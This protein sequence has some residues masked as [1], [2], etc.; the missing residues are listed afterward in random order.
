MN[1]PYTVIS[2]DTLM[3]RWAMSEMDIFQ[4]VLNRHLLPA[5]LAHPHPE[6]D[7]IEYDFLDAIELFKRKKE[8]GNCS[9]IFRMSDIENLERK[10]GGKLSKS[11]SIISGEKL[12][13][14]W[15][16]SKIE[17]EDLIKNLKLDVVDPLNIKVKDF[18][19]MNYED[20]HLTPWMDTDS[21]TRYFRK[22]DVEGL[23]KAHSI[24]PNGSQI[25]DDDKIGN[26]K[27]LNGNTMINYNK[28]LDVLHEKHKIENNPQKRL[29]LE[30]Y[31]K[32]AEEFLK[33]AN[34]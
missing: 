17:I 20:L 12:C 19:E 23:E 28:C 24:G 18:E 27:I 31:I 16:K 25:C 33:K 34:N 26:P 29:E 15:N 2:I 5:K 21:M 13:K 11:S 9:I 22:T 10:L 32:V 4:I 3:L 7:L 6:A 8:N 1:L 30:S 14:R